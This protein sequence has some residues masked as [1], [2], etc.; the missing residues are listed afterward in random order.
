MRAFADFLETTSAAASTTTARNLTTTANVKTAL[1]IS[2]STWDDLFTFLIP[3]VTKMIVDDCRLAS[4]AS[5]SVPTFARETLRATWQVDPD[6]YSGNDQTVRGVDLFLPWR[7][8]VYSI[9]S[10]VE[11]GNTRTVS[12]DYVLM[13][14]RPG[15]LRRVSS[16]TPVEWSTG[17]IVVVFKAGFDVTSSLATS[18]DPV[19]ESAA[20]EQIKAMFY[21]ANRDPALRSENVPDVAA[22]SWSV[23]GGDTM[24][25]NALLPTVRDMLAPW[26][27]PSP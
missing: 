21:A 14:S 23:P 20:I 1:K 3:R 16:D 24:G 27:K 9:D 5:G 8:P 19:I 4:D 17:K 15:R 7:L 13:S 26:R 6:A 2:V 18:I 12:T 11:D 22:V 25:A 10:V